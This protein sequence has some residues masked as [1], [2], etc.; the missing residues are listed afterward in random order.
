MTSAQVNCT[1]MLL[2]PLVMFTSCNQ[3]IV[4][5]FFVYSCHRSYRGNV[6]PRDITEDL[7]PQEIEWIREATVQVCYTSNH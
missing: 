3:V 5:M 4:Q 7:V 6:L 2:F 1:L